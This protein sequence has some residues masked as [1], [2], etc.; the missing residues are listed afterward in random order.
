MQKLGETNQKVGKTSCVVS[1]TP[2]PRP[3]HD[4]IRAQWVLDVSLEN[5]LE[6]V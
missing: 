6:R 5:M 2:S 1:Q 4:K 3:K